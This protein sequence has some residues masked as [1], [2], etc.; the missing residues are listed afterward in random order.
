MFEPH[1]V[2]SRLA[3]AGL[4]DRLRADL[5]SNPDGGENPTLESFLEASSRHLEGV[6]L[7]S[8]NVGS[9]IDPE[10]LAWQL[11]ALVRLGARVSE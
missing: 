2:T 7:S 10:A 4:V 11:F 3:P 6:P 5:V 1:S 9:T 8:K